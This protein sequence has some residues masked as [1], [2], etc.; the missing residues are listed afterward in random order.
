MHSQLGT[1]TLQMVIQSHSGQDEVIRSDRNSH[2]QLSPVGGFFGPSAVGVG[3][4]CLVSGSPGTF[5]ST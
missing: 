4:S 1:G 3:M 2:R 5:H